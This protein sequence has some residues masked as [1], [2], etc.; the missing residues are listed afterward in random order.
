[1]AEV[2]GLEKE[3]VELKMNYQADFLEGGFEVW[4]NAVLDFETA[5][6][7]QMGDPFMDMLLPSFST[8]GH[9]EYIAGM[10][11]VMDSLKPFFTYIVEVYACGIPA[12]SLEGKQEDWIALK[13]KTRA[14]KQYELDWWLNDVEAILDQFI[15]AFRGEI[16]KD[17]W[18]NM[19]KIH[20]PQMC[21]DT[22]KIDGWITN[23]FPYDRFGRRRAGEA[24]G[25]IS[26]LPEEVLKVDFKLRIKYPDRIKEF[27]MQLVSGFLGAEQTEKDFSLRPLI[28]WMVVEAEKKNKIKS[29]PQNAFSF[30]YANLTEFPEEVLSLKKSFCLD[31][32]FIDKIDIPKALTKKDLFHLGIKGNISHKEKRW[33]LRNFPFSSLQINDE[34][35]HDLPG[36]GWFYRL[37]RGLWYTFK[38]L[39]P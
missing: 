6:R 24:I 26:D 33:L 14:L 9:K 22:E 4:E 19:F 1:M 28:S 10:I 34:Y 5:L 2:L 39:M 25:E 3:K 37:K 13:E 31:L 29:L 15:S 32:Y 35:Y 38:R 30:S 11:S 17:F 8:T 23:F 36:H 7:G 16:D 27:P 18:R 12:V 21:G 20:K